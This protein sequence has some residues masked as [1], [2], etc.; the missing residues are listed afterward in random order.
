M[1]TNCIYCGKQY[2]QAAAFKKHMIICEI[3]PG[4]TINFRKSVVTIPN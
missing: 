1:P 3:L 4:T 2:K